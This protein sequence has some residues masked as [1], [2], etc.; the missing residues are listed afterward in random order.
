M[1]VFFILIFGGE[2]REKGGQTLVLHSVAPVTSVS[3]L[4]WCTFLCVLY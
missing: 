4:F 3:D 1:N 2:E